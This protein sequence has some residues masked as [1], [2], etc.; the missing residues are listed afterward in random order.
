MSAGRLRALL[1]ALACGGLGVS[2]ATSA[3]AAQLLQARDKASKPGAPHEPLE[4]LAGRFEQEIRW[5]LEPGA[6]PT[7]SKGLA[8]VTRIMG[9][10]YVKQQLLAEL[11]GEPFQALSLIG[12]DNQKR[13]YVSVWIDNFSSG[14]L[15]C[16]GRYD[17]EAR[18]FT[19]V[20]SY[21]DPLTGKKMTARLTTR[22]VDADHQLFERYE[23]L[24]DGA[25]I[26]TMEIRAT[27]VS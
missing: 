5:W 19:F 6:E 9:G 21:E 10:R 24:P 17:A 22:I 2:C 27:R 14:I 18:L 25:E 23:T 8:E 3:T 11:A 4:A 1:L 26:K 20:G 13:A 7:L 12:Y 15:N 16:V